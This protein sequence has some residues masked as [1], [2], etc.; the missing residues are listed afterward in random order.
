MNSLVK[1]PLLWMIVYDRNELK[2]ID[3][4]GN[5]VLWADRARQLAQEEISYAADRGAWLIANNLLDAWEK[6]QLYA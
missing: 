2:G 5:P 6:G 1:H 4:V 3:R